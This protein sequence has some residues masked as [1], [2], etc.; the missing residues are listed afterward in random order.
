MMSKPMVMEKDNFQIWTEYTSTEHLQKLKNFHE[1][2]TL[3]G[4][5]IGSVKVYFFTITFSFR[6]IVKT[7]VFKGT[8]N[9]YIKK[10]SHS[11]DIPL[12]K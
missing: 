12:R 11:S 2:S 9:L 5:N 8:E 6:E 7:E 3:K 4:F 10:G 1:I